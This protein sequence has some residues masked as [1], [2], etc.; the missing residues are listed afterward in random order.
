MAKTFTELEASDI[1][2]DNNPLHKSL[3]IGLAVSALVVTGAKKDAIDKQA[4]ARRVM[5][6][7]VAAFL[8]GLDR[9]GYSITKREEIPAAF[10]NLQ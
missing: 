9:D 1:D 7:G 8:N 3:M 2:L 5:R 4:E 10:L 6:E